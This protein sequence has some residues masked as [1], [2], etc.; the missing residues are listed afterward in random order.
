M[1]SEPKQ[2]RVHKFA[3]IWSHRR[4]EMNRL[5]RSFYTRTFK[6][7]LFAGDPVDVEQQS[8]YGIVMLHELL[9]GWDSAPDAADHGMQLL[10]DAYPGSSAGYAAK[11]CLRDMRLLQGRWTDALRL[12]TGSEV[13]SMT[14]GLADELDHPR[15]NPVDVLWFDSA[16]GLTRGPESGCSTR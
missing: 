4:P 6:P 2:Q 13:P 12:T 14:I 7:G 11:V 9:D 3:E 5:Q 1:A 8:G 15:L 10:M 16:R